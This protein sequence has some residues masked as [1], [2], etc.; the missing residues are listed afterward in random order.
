MSADAETKLKNLWASVDNNRSFWLTQPSLANAIAAAGFSS[1]Y[2]CLNPYH[3][4]PG[5]RRAYVALKCLSAEILSSPATAQMPAVTY[6]EKGL[7]PTSESKNPLVRLISRS[8]PGPFVN[9]LHGAFRRIHPK[10]FRGAVAATVQEN[11]SLSREST[12]L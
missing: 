10:S 1:F 5:D 3:A 2:E 12:K 9:S 8:L 6:S 7:P 11:E 4:V